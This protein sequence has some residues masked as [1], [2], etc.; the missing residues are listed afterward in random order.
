MGVAVGYFVGF[1]TA[2]SAYTSPPAELANDRQLASLESLIDEREDAAQV[3]ADL[4]ITINA[5]L[6]FD[7]ASRALE[8]LMK[9][10]KRS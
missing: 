10:P 7:D 8:A 9:P 4:G 1:F 2:R 3:L 6:S 5:K